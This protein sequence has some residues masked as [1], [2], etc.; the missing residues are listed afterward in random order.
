MARWQKGVSGNPSGKPKGTVSTP[1]K[2]R[3]AIAED[4]TGIINV[5]R[6]KAREGD[7]QAAALLLSRVLPPLRSESATAS[8]VA[9]S[10]ESLGERAEGIVRAALA[11]ELPPT[12]ADELMGLLAQQARIIEISELERRLAMLEEK[13]A[14]PTDSKD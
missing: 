10:G 1:G 4:L 7:V 13:N 5:L 8:P 3:Q 2:L 6:K 11:G 9:V 12:V 14:K